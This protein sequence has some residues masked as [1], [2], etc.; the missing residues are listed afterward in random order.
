MRKYVYTVY[1]CK[2]SCAPQT[3]ERERERE[4]DRQTDRQTDR[5][6]QKQ[7]YRDRDGMR[8]VGKSPT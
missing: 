7:T 5:Q 1:L 3:G 4:R 8:S 6:R 2:L